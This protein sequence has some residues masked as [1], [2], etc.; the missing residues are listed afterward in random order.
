MYYSSMAAPPLKVVTFGDSTTAPR[1][2]VD[3]YT[4]QLRRSFAAKGASVDF[5]NRGVGGN[6]TGMAAHRFEKDVLSE[7]PNLVIVQFGIN[8]ASIDVWK[9]PPCTEPRISIAAFEQ[10]LR[11]FVR[12]IE[13]CGGLVVLMTPNQMR[14]TDTLR[15]RYGH[16]PYDPKQETGFSAVLTHYANA[17]RGLAAEADLPLVDIFA[18]YDTWEEVNQLSCSKL[19]T[20]GIHPNSE[21]H[22]L[23]ANA[24]T[25]E[26]DRALAAGLKAN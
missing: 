6:D 26:I 17:T 2:G 18:L 25:P 16:P 15:E 23:V 24:L 20:D 21:G 3:I 10:N 19:L 22:S 11:H 14:W 4:D 8:D 9:S 12:E 7:K 13:K 5:I 1:L